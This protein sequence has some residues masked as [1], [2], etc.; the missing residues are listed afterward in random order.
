[1]VGGGVVGGGVVG[2][3]VVLFGFTM[4]T[5]FVFVGIAFLWHAAKAMKQITTKVIFLIIFFV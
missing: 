2:G 1:M 5:L 3:G 4:V